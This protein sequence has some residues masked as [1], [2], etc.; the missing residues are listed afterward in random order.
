MFKSLIFLLVCFFTAHLH[1]DE[2]I[3]ILI[4]GPSGVGKSTII[5]H[6]QEMDSRF[7]YIS[8]YTTRDLRPGETDKIHVSLEEMQE[9]EREGKLLTINKIYDTYYATPKPLIDQAL[10]SQQFPI[11]DWPVDKMRVMQEAYKKRIFSVYIE[12]ENLKSLQEHL[13]RDGR[14]PDG[15]RLAAGLEELERYDQGEFDAWLDMKVVNI[16]GQDQLVA[17]TL[18]SALIHRSVNSASSL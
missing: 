7:V 6:L 16:E 12:P 17:E 18:H 8:P 14:D 3:F 13:C 10:A 4:L 2:G 5:H 11:L 15:R 1:S 9:L